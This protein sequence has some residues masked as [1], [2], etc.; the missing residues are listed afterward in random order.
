MEESRFK[1]YTQFLR[2][3]AGLVAYT[4]RLGKEAMTTLYP[5]MSYM[6]EEEFWYRCLMMES[7]AVMGVDSEESRSRRAPWGS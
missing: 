4:V 7:L 6:M 5:S 1:V 3:L 2:F